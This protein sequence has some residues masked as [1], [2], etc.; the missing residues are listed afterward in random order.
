MLN[1]KY[2]SM[3]TIIFISAFITGFLAGCNPQPAATLP[4]A[5]ANTVNAFRPEKTSQ[6]YPFEVTRYGDFR[7]AYLK[8]LGLKNERGC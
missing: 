2:R 5:T 3:K 1:H 7:A 6:I 8:S 4:A